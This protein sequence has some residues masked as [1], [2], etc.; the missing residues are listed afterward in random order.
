M[1]KEKRGRTPPL[2]LWLKGF[3]DCFAPKSLDYPLG[4]RG[5]GLHRVLL[6]L[7]IGIAVGE[8]GDT[9][10]T[11]IVRWCKFLIYV[12]VSNVFRFSWKVQD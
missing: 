8:K 1:L 10:G 11:I 3:S 5:V 4:R 12:F 7:S 6:R 9:E 2:F